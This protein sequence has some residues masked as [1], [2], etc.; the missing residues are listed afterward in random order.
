MKRKGLS[1]ILYLIIAASVLMMIAMVITFTATDVIGGAGSSSTKKQCLNTVQGLCSA[2][3]ADYI[4]MPSSCITQNSMTINA[5]PSSR[6]SQKDGS[7]T[8]SSSD[9][10]GCEVI[11]T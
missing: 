8:C 3:N 10:T 4:D 5:L 2:T 6:V 11:C 7:G 9:E 1:Q